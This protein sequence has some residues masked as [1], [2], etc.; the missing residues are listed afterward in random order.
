MLRKNLI[1]SSCTILTIA[2]VAA[3]SLTLTGAAPQDQLQEGVETDSSYWDFHDDGVSEVVC[4]PN[5]YLMG[6]IDR[7][8]GPL[9]NKP[10]PIESG[11]VCISRTWLMNV[12]DRAHGPLPL[13]LNPPYSC[14]QSI[15]WV[16]NEFWD[17]CRTQQVG[18][19]MCDYCYFDGG[20]N[21]CES[22]C[23]QMMAG[24]GSWGLPELFDCLDMCYDTCEPC[25][26]NK[27]RNGYYWCCYALDPECP[28]CEG[29]PG[30]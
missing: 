5:E 1:R 6:L 15:C 19:D 27:Y 29:Q 12:I 17:D 11:L 8:F 24:C 23:Y 16:V 9:P 28:E 3:L 20:P 18:C 22:M 25:N 13:A 14:Y 26:C 10:D 2:C 21:D 30:E 7:A 4:L